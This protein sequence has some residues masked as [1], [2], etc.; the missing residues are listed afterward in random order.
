MI[1]AFKAV[2]IYKWKREHGAVQGNYSVSQVGYLSAVVNVRVL[3]RDKGGWE[4]GD[5]WVNG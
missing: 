2:W 3:M 4:R 1:D 5:R